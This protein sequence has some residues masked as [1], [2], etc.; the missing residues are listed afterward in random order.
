MIIRKKPALN[1]D[2]CDSILIKWKYNDEQDSLGETV[3]NE[4]FDQNREEDKFHK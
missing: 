3:S 1:A 4:V 2:K